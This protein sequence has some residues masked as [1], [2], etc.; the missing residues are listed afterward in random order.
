MLSPRLNGAKL[1]VDHLGCAHGVAA[2]HMHRPPTN[3]G[4]RILQAVIGLIW[5][6][7]QQCMGTCLEWVELSTFLLRPNAPKSNQVA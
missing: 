2:A 3:T 4:R 6:K 7:S 1:L 5:S